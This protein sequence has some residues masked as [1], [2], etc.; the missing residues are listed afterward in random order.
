MDL[1]SF[2]ANISKLGGPAVSHRFEISIP[3]SGDNS[4]VWQRKVT[5]TKAGTLADSI[6]KVT[7]LTA[8]LPGKAFATSEERTYGPIRKRPYSQ[9]FTDAAFTFMGTR[10]MPEKKFFDSWMDSIQDPDTFDF[11]YYN[12]F[13][14]NVTVTQ[15]DVTNKPVYQCTLIEAWPLNIGAIALDWGATNEYPRLT[16]TMAYRRWKDDFQKEISG[17]FNG[18]KVSSTDVV[19]EDL[20]M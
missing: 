4:R 12:N 16:V 15:F 11:E 10:H 7:C 6:F 18:V 1:S 2:K 19:N 13:T 8:E 3:Y 20:F 5:P 17:R 9:F 14:T